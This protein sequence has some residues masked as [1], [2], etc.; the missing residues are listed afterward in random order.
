V[1]TDAPVAHPAPLDPAVDRPDRLADLLDR[2]AGAG[3]EP[4]VRWQEQDLA[5]VA[6]S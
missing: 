6:A 2:L 5:V 4:V 3:L 1:V